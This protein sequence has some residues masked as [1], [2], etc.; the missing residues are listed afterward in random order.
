MNPHP[1][2]SHTHA[3]GNTELQ[4]CLEALLSGKCNEGDFVD[5]VRGKCSENE[6]IDAIAVQLRRVPAD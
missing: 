6:F 4:R 3:H 2:F 5:S 1:D